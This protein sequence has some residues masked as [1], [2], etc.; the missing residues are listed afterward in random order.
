MNRR[1][2]ENVFEIQGKI[3]CERIS[4]IACAGDCYSDEVRLP[5]VLIFHIFLS[6]GR[7][8]RGTENHNNESR[9]QKYLNLKV[10]PPARIRLVN[11]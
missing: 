11:K 4:F 7:C 1:S 10:E 2:G 9:R 8:I 5:V 6:K 3:S